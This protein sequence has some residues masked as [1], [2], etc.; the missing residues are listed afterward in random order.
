[1]TGENETEI[2]PQS[3]AGQRD[4]GDARRTRAQNNLRRLRE[5][6]LLSKAEFARKAGLSALT[7]D[8]VESGKPCRMN[9][10]RKII[11][12][13]GLA[14]EDKD[15]VFEPDADGEEA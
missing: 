1:M 5:E 15:Q 11:L 13:L 7:I 4:E 14:I 9:T 10:K 6:R 2:N 8:R 3:R 12:A